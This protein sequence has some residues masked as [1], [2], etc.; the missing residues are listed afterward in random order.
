M[1]DVRYFSFSVCFYVCNT[2][3]LHIQ[4][5]F[6]MALHISLNVQSLVM[7][8]ASHSILPDNAVRH[9]MSPCT[10]APSYFAYPHSMTSHSMTFSYL[11][12]PQL[13]CLRRR[14]MSLYI[15]TD[16]QH[17][18]ARIPLD[19]IL[20]WFPLWCFSF[21]SV[22]LKNLHAS[23]FVFNSQLGLVVTVCN[24]ANFLVPFPSVSSSTQFGWNDLSPV[25]F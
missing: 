10:K 12:S 17:T 2:S 18:A 22:H 3:L 11:R 7:R 19:L 16:I 13:W 25:L 24:L 5:Y 21:L 15:M 8:T 9:L 20:P 1:A 6:Q 23:A 4:I 14:L